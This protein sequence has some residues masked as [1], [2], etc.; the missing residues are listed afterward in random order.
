MLSV[1]N[2]KLFEA[3]RSS[4]WNWAKPFMNPKMGIMS[5]KKDFLRDYQH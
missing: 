1:K 3:F 2:S 4:F 5:E